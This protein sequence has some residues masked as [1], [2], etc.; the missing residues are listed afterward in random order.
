MQMDRKRRW[1]A[2]AGTAG[3]VLL[4]VSGCAQSERGSGGD[5]GATLNFGQASAPKLFDPFYATDGETF[6]ITEQMFDNLV[7]FKTGTSQVEPGLATDWQPSDG[8]KTW[9]FNLRKNVKFTD[10]TAMD[11]TAVCKNFER[12]YNQKGAG[13]SNAVSQYWNDNFGGFA[14][15]KQPSLYAGCEVKSPT[16]MAL[17]LTKASSKMPDILGLASWAIQSPTA[18]DKYHANDVKAEGDSFVYPDYATKHPTGTGPFKFGKYDQANGTVELVRNDNY[19]GEKPKLAKIVFK[20][21]KDTAGTRQ[22]LQAGEIDGYDL[23]QPQDY[24]SLRDQGNKLLEREPFNIMYL[25]IDQKNNPKLRD[26]KVRQAIAYAINRPQLVKSQYPDKAVVAKEMLPPSIAGFNPNVPEYNYDPNKAK[27]LLKEAGAEGLTVNFYWPSEVTRPYL[28]SPRDQFTA[29]KGDLEKVGIKV[30]EKS[31][32][33]NGGY[34]D[35]VEGH[36]PDLF[37]MGWNGDFN[38]ADNFFSQFFNT[39]TNR[40]YAAASPWG[41]SLSERVKQLDATADKAAREQGYQELNGQIQKDYL[42][43]VPIVSAPS[44]IAVKD[45]IKGLVPSPLSNEKFEL[46]E[47]SGS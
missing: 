9:S 35:D 10:G 32:P 14:D 3:A 25:G 18:M 44:Y 22:A 8:G 20:I 5:N 12:M 36:K 46:V 40:F 4:V 41:A 30:V 15:K 17:K 21:Y 47:K 42:P 7:E 45:N 39:P 31:E 28:P 29:M 27:Q 13:T 11:A 26:L 6:R 43:A 24:Q 38:N 34:L 37:L 16:R 33:W 23:P 1:V 2:A 19:W